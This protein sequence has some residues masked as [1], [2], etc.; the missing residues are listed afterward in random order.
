MQISG[1]R[2]SLRRS[3]WSWFPSWGSLR[4][5]LQRGALL[6]TVPSSQGSVLWWASTEH[7]APGKLNYLIQPLL[8][9]SH[10]IREV[11]S[12]SERSS[13]FWAQ[14]R[15]PFSN[16]ATHHQICPQSSVLI[17]L[18]ITMLLNPDLS[19]LFQLCEH[20]HRI[21]LLLPDHAPEVLHSVP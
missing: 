8:W 11:A 14:L 6:C 19:F 4:R 15:W 10:L 12:C 1:V 7:F 21:D 2:V 18:S 17:P 20:D 13:L 5:N 3:L 16:L 9:A